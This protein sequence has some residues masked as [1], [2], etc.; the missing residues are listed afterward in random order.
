MNWETILHLTPI[1]QIICLY[2]TA[3]RYLATGD[4][5]RTI[6]FS[7]WVG[8]STV[9]TVI[10]ETCH[11]IWTALQPVYMKP[12]TRMVEWTKISEDFCSLWNFP[13]C[14]GAIDGKHVNIQ[15]PPNSG[16]EFYNYKGFRSIVLLAVCDANYCFTLVDV[17]DNG[18]H[19]DGGVL[20]HSDF[21][22]AMNNRQLGLPGPSAI[23]GTTTTTPYMFV[24]DEAFPLKECLQRPY[25]GRN[26]TERKRIFNYRLSRARRTIEN[27][28]GILAAR[29]RVFHR[30]I[31]VT[32]EKAADI[33][34]AT[35]CL[36]NFLK[37]DESRQFLPTRRYCLQHF[38]DYEDRSGSITLG[39]WRSL[40]N[41]S[42]GMSSIQRT[43]T[44]M[45]SHSAS[46]IRDSLAEFFDSP[47]GMLSWQ[48]S[49]I[50]SCGPQLTA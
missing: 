15:A 45:Y 43:G 31:N 28:F 46:E 1:L 39:D 47:E 19:S 8:H 27:T 42:L 11:A 48:Y 30:P 33:V 34:K 50:R 41:G 12:P 36:H 17:G 6:S 3:R 9:C 49:Y 26:L 22:I 32:P 37:V 44:N 40:V 7:Y 10:S 16:S 21:G 23:P 20:T 14:V 2:F 18:R 25:P 24:G 38:T 4:S 13:N 35:C 29:W 5:M